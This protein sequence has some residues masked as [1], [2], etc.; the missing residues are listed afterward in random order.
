MECVPL[1]QMQKLPNCSYLE[2]EIFVATKNN[3]LQHLHYHF[4][5]N[6]EEM[7]Q[8]NRGHADVQKILMK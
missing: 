1:D 4:D 8:R 6:K 7:E 3:F 2:K 5:S